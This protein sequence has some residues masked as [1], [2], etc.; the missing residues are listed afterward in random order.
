VLEHKGE[1]R[2]RK[3]NFTLLN[4]SLPLLVG[5]RSGG[6][7]KLHCQNSPAL[8]QPLS[9]TSRSMLNKLNWVVPLLCLASL[10]AF[11]E[12]PVPRPKTDSPRMLL[13]TSVM[14]DDQ[15]QVAKSIGFSHSQTDSDHLTVNETSP[16]V[17]DW[18][19]ADAGLA[20][21][22]K[23]G[24]QW[25]YFPHFHWPPEWYRKTD[26][27]VPCIGLR[28]KRKV[29]AISIW[30]PDIVPWFEHGYAALAQHYGSGT[31]N[32]FA[33]Y[34]GI[35]GDFGETIFPMGW[36]PDEKKRFAEN[37][38]PVPDFW[39]DDE[40][41]RADF[42]K[43]ASEKYKSVSK[44]N[45]AWGTHF[46]KFPEIEYP[47]AALDKTA[48]V[49]DTAQSRRYWLDF[50]DWYYASMTRFTKD[51]CRI[52]RQNFPKAL[53]ELPV[54]GGSEDVL[55]GQDTTAIPKIAKEFDV[56]IRST[57][58]GFQ[59]FAQNYAGMLKKISTA[60]KIYDVPHWLEPPSAITPDG[61]VARIMEA[62]SCANYGFWDWGANP[63]T[64]AQVF[65]DYTN[66]FTREQPVVDV[67]LLFPTTDHRLH[68]TISLP[69]KLQSDGAEL[70]DVIDFDMVDEPLISDDALNHYRVL[71]WIEGQYVEQRTLRKIDAWIR[72]GGVFVSWETNSIETVEG[73]RTFAKSFG[74]KFSPGGVVVCND[75]SFL[76]HLSAIP[77]PHT[78]LT[79]LSVPPRTKVLATSQGR[80]AVWA[81]PQKKGW[82]VAAPGLDRKCWN[83]LVRD[84]VYNLHQLD[85]LKNDALEAD[86]GF[87][88]TYTTLLKTGE[89]LLYNSTAESRTNYISGKRVHI[90]PKSLRSII[91]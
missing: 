8:V 14:S 63:M 88:G 62:L 79:A 81:V 34:L 15:N 52:A 41:A 48:T 5:P 23:A 28:S 72:Q 59:P 7:T 82:I 90:P 56:H 3:G 6:S 83:E 29:D 78:D 55:Y 12:S 80:P 38:V 58:G 39:C 40:F 61:E 11:G 91:P 76:R 68:P 24:M 27:F 45:S 10:S 65:R 77:E 73:D 19:Q 13:G 35:H 22:K 43:F 16:G 47:P 66:Y 21:M 37:Q 57:H 36:H 70:R 32:I 50:L 49:I 64:A 86:S 87:D 9:E 2:R 4:G 44:L 69:R 84:V 46:N 71:V 85:P 30:S 51:V 31:S 26:K 17:W 18:S 1:W 54:G 33:I 42:R 74:A 75:T 89:V 67:A 60:C 20:T 53:L 25:Q